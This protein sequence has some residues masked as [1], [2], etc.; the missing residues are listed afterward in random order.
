[1]GSTEVVD[2]GRFSGR[3]SNSFSQTCSL[4]SQYLKQKGGSLGELA[5]CLAPNFES[6]GTM[7][8]LPM[9]EKSDAKEETQT[10]PE[11]ETAQMTIFY[12]GQVIVFNDFPADKAK[13]VM[14][15][16]SNSCATKNR[17]SS[18]CPEESATSFPNIVR[19]FGIPEQTQHTPVQPPLGSDLPIAR[20]NSLA[21]FLGKRKDRI[22]ENAPY[23]AAG[24]KP[25]SAA[26]KPFTAEAWLGLGAREFQR[27]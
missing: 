8:L 5:Q 19:S 12:A 25:P 2:S 22:T 16:A 15:L 21:R 4:L 3:R 7:N 14:V 6:K 18:H 17:H 26:A 9:I 20:K 11:A 27:D 13:D 23:Q 24:I 10:K 1:M